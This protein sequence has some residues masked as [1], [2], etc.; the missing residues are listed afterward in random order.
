MKEEQ[1]TDRVPF[2]DRVFITGYTLCLLQT[3]SSLGR[4]TINKSNTYLR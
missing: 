3:L 4:I 2:V 1:V